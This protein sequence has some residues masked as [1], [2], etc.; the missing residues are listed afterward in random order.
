MTDERI[1]EVEAFN[2]W[3]SPCKAVGIVVYTQRRKD[4]ISG[5]RAAERLAKIEVLEDMSR[6]MDKLRFF[7][8][9]EYKDAKDRIETKIAELKEAR[10]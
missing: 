6:M 9:A 5:F 8:V 4:F 3:W 2:K 1:K 7:S 10:E